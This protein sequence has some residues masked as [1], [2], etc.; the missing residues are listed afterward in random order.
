MPAIRTR[1]LVWSLA[2]LAL[3]GI[4]H[5]ADGKAM[6]RSA[7]LAFSQ[8]ALPFDAATVEHLLNRAGFGATAADID[9]ALALGREAFL[10]KLFHGFAPDGERF[11][12][13]EPD[14]PGPAER[15]AMD[16]EMRRQ[17]FQRIRREDNRQLIEFAGWWVDEMVA[18]RHPLR[19]RMVLFWHG[20]FTSSAKD[21]KNGRAMIRQNELFRTHA[22][23]SY[24]DLLRA[25]PRDPAM[26]VYLNNDKNT[27]S[28]PN[29]NLARE[30]MELFSLGEGNYGE[31]DVK[32]AA[33]ALTGAG[34]RDGRYVFQRR[35]H[36][37][38]Q[39]TVL[40]VTGPL[41]GAA[42][43]EILLD[44]EACARWV[45]G[46]LLEHFEGRVP[47]KARLE[48]YAKTLR[49]AE[50]RI[51]PLLRRLFDDPEF[52]SAEVVGQRIT[53]PIEFLVGNCRRLGVLP[54]G[55]V[56]SAGAGLIGQQI[57]GPPS[58]KGWDGGRAWIT[59][60]TFLQRG[61]LAGMLLGVTRVED[62]L[63]EDPDFLGAEE[64]AM[65][66]EMSGEMSDEEPPPMEAD[67]KRDDP[68]G[69]ASSRRP[70]RK[71]GGNNDGNYG[72]GGLRLMEAG[73]WR[74]ELDLR[75]R[76]RSAG[77]RSDD[78]I[79]DRLAADLL[80]VALSPESKVALV[81]YLRAERSARDLDEGTWLDK[82][83]YGEAILR[84]LAHLILSLPEAQ[85]N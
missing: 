3:A 74:R 16:E 77:A 41:D 21:V 11:E 32:E 4:G 62:I 64:G 14:R 12:V 25:I 5:A 40:G 50:Y 80:A 15:R 17:T 66:G 43:V 10:E 75:E 27:K 81:E 2:A 58:V 8:N 53:G 78:A 20:F 37:D 69:D 60:S 83:A 42:V 68:A 36:D 7:P 52:Y 35:Q 79:V 73:R 70:R 26:L 57:F 65:S 39:K 1:S 48:S 34:A 31:Q 23:G 45:A 71:L 22:L 44:Q 49:D 55:A 28:A 38:G 67:G 33:R 29:E 56:I 84:Q 72:N 24:A 82:K 59:T 63:N 46:K 9:A 54:P 51:E 76:C 61:N 6:Q 13:V 47:S 18:S 19:E 85:L 30:L